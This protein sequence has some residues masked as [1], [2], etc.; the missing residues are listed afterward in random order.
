[1][2]DP[3]TGSSS[4]QY[5][6]AAEYESASTVRSLGWHIQNKSSSELF[7]LLCAA[8]SAV[9]ARVVSSDEATSTVL[10]TE[11]ATCD[12][13]EARTRPARPRATLAF[14]PAL[15]GEFHLPTTLAPPTLR[16]PRA[17]QASSLGFERSE[18]MS[19]L[20]WVAQGGDHEGGHYICIR[21]ASGDTFMYHAFY[22]R[23]REAM[24]EANGWVEADGAYVL[25]ADP[26]APPDLHSAAM[27]ASG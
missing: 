12:D 9:G 18:R 7:V 15:D 1:M 20:L 2:A 6:L 11:D 10:A 4:P 27:V 3:P 16:S 13:H 19:V 24:A 5:A 14:S 26:T 25:S 21:R 17:R 8:V 23:V 22:R